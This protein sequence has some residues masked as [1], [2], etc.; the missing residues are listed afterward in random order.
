[1]LLRLKLM[2]SEKESESHYHSTSVGGLWEGGQKSLEGVR[3]GGEGG[4]EV[5]LRGR[6]S[7]GR[8]LW[9]R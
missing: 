4:S 9:L 3:R 6:H 5:T 2:E 1:M 7:S 8:T